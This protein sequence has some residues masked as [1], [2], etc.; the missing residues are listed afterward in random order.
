MASFSSALI[1]NHKELLRVIHF[2][3]RGFKFNLGKHPGISYH[4]ETEFTHYKFRITS[5][6]VYFAEA[7]EQVC[8]CEKKKK[9]EHNKLTVLFVFINFFPFLCFVFFSI[10]LFSSQ[11]SYFFYYVS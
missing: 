4:D 7:I 9:K 8:I 6:G 10:F 2:Q 1:E 11:L 3:N 5:V